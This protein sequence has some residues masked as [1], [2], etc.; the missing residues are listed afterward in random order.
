MNMLSWW[1]QSVLWLVDKKFWLLFVKTFFNS[2]IIWMRYGAP[3]V[4]LA[5]LLGVWSLHHRIGFDVSLLMQVALFMWLLIVR[6]SLERK[7]FS[8]MRSRMVYVLAYFL[9]R[10]TAALLAIPLLRI[11][12]HLALP[13]AAEGLMLVM[14][15]VLLFIVCLFT[16]LCMLDS[17]HPVRSIAK[18]VIRGFILTFR[19]FPAVL[20]C[21]LISYIFLAFIAG[22]SVSAGI[23]LLRVTN[24]VS[25]GPIHACYLFAAYTLVPALV[26]AD[27]LM[28]AGAFLLIVFVTN[29]YINAR[30]ASQ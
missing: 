24:A 10:T 12:F 13:R 11:G 29:L 6:P 28:F 5:V 18:S 2:G 19:V 15:E 20:F 26:Q 3:L 4:L 1:K 16:I 14:V 30:Y 27:V 25:C 17:E 8:Y 7:D 23:W 22:L 9:Y 21:W